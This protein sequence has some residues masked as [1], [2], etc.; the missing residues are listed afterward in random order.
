MRK[1]K[2]LIVCLVGLLMALV[3]TLAGCGNCIGDGDCYYIISSGRYEW[4][5]DGDCGVYY[6]VVPVTQK[7][8][9]CDC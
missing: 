8:I 2:L 9:D 5:G 6:S 1:S 4:C 3:L 7:R